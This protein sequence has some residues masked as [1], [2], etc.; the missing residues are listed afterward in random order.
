MFLATRLLSPGKFCRSFA[1]LVIID[2]GQAGSHSVEYKKKSMWSDATIM[3]TKSFEKWARPKLQNAEDAKWHFVMANYMFSMA[4]D[5]A[6]RQCE[7][8]YREA[9]RRCEEAFGLDPSRWDIQIFRS[10]ILSRLKDHEACIRVLNALRETMTLGQDEKYDKAY[11]KTVVPGMGDCHVNLEAYSQAASWFMLSYQ[12]H[13][14]KDEF[15]DATEDMTCKLLK[16]HREQKGPQ[17]AW[18]IIRTLDSRLKNNKSWLSSMLEDPGSD[19]HELLILLAHDSD[20]YAIVGT[21]YDRTI[22]GT[23]EEA[24]K[25]GAR[26]LLEYTKGRLYVY[27]GPDDT[28]SLVLSRWET[29]A[30]HLRDHDN[31]WSWWTRRQLIQEYIKASFSSSSQS[32]VE[33]HERQQEINKLNKLSEINNDLK[34]CTAYTARPNSLSLD[35]CTHMTGLMRLANR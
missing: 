22:K 27:C 7:R 30:S 2:N 20:A 35:S 15:S 19:L 26:H 24:K 29:I 8:Q 1:H 10:Q 14:E 32:S 28:R 25:S 5:R 12:F 16:A 11:W 13:L 21:Y 33:Q 18:E 6:G 34:I 3:E 31:D 17:K 4:L 9:C 23:D